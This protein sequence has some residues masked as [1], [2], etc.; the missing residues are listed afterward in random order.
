MRRNVYC[1]YK[2]GLF[3]LYELSIIIII[4]RP[5]YKRYYLSSALDTC[6]V[7]FNKMKVLGFHGKQIR[8]VVSGCSVWHYSEKKVKEPIKSSANQVTSHLD[9][10]VNHATV[11]Q[12]IWNMRPKKS[13]LRSGIK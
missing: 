7:S 3:L 4:I 10:S 6:L 1:Y 12:V 11:V 8:P 13:V 2:K 9:I 5:V